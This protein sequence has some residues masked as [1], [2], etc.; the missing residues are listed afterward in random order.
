M[1]LSTALLCL[2]ATVY[3]E[4]R[5]ETTIGQAAVAQVAFN[6]AGQNPDHVCEVVTKRKQFSWT[7]GS[8]VERKKHRI[9]LTKKGYPHDKK[10][11]DTA[12][13]IAA[14]TLRGSIKDFTKGATYYHASYV[15]PYWNRDLKLVSTIGLHKFYRV[16]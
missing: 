7:N 1:M 4:S 15:R 5:S 10:A 13:K 12:V 3:H 8:L 6:R 2:A 11:W 14:L 16:A 9:Y